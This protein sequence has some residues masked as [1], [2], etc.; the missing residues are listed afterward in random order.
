[1]PL[2]SLRTKKLEALLQVHFP[3]M[4]RIIVCIADRKIYRQAPKQA[5]FL[6]W[7]LLLSCHRKNDDCCPITEIIILSVTGQQSSFSIICLIS[8]KKVKIR[9]SVYNLIMQPYIYNESYSKESLFVIRIHIVRMF[10]QI[11]WYRMVIAA[12]TWQCESIFVTASTALQFRDS[13]HVKKPRGQRG[14]R[15]TLRSALHSSVAVR[16]IYI[17]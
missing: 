15:D 7:H 6:L 3:D 2:H 1:M 12:L 9:Y 10:S 11:E 4:N 5:P 17:L 13:K 8:M 14:S 16:T